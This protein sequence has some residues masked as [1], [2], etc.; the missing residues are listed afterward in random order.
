MLCGCKAKAIQPVLKDGNTVVSV[1]DIGEKSIDGKYTE[2]VSQLDNKEQKYILNTENDRLVFEERKNQI[3]QFEAAEVNNRIVVTDNC[4]GNVIHD[5]GMMSSGYINTFGETQS[6]QLSNTGRY[7]FYSKI[8]PHEDALVDLIKKEKIHIPNMGKI[9]YIKWS[10]DDKKAFIDIF[11]PEKNTDESYILDMEN[12]KL[13][14]IA[15]ELKGEKYW[16]PDDNYI[17]Y[18]DVQEIDNTIGWKITR[19]DIR[20]DKWNDIYSTYGTISEDDIKWLS[21]EELIFLEIRTSSN[22]FKPNNYFA[23]KVNLKSNQEIVRQLD[24]QNVR[25]YIWS[26]N[27]KYIYFLD[28][29]GFFKSEVDFDK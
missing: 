2:I 23:V 11:F 14:K 17:Y 15:G 24:A 9:V 29:N 18:A 7:L 4:T 3:N 1:K 20:K 26:Y 6:I 12:G 10:N 8:D 13:N 22:P 25:K 21:D 27:N 16:T 28:D 19:Y 5:V